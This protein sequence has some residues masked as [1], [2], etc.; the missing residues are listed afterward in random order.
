MWRADEVEKEKE[1]SSMVPIRE[2]VALGSYEVSTAPNSQAAW[3][4]RSRWACLRNNNLSFFPFLFFCLSARAIKGC[5]T[6][7]CGKVRGL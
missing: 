1:Q 6:A 2:I 7:V 3:H 5:Y 4:D